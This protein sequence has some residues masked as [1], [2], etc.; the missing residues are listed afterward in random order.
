VILEASLLVYL[1]QV[2]LAKLLLP[3]PL[4]NKLNVLYF[5]FELIAIKIN[6]LVVIETTSLSLFVSGTFKFYILD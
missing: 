1:L 3:V 5:L 2:D 4:I 6:I